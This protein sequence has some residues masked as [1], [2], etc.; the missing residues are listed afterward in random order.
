MI[1][2]NYCF[3]GGASPLSPYETLTRY[4]KLLTNLLCLG[5]HV[6]VKY[7]YTVVCSCFCLSVYLSVCLSRDSSLTVQFKC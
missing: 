4:M 2:N 5:V 1:N 3:D 6:Q 7:M